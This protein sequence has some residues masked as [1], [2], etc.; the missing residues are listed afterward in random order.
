MMSSTI[1]AG[2]IGAHLSRR[3]KCEWGGGEGSVTLT[4]YWNGIVAFSRVWLRF[5]KEPTKYR[6]LHCFGWHDGHINECM[7][8]DIPWPREPISVATTVLQMIT[9]SK[10]KIVGTKVLNQAISD[11]ISTNYTCWQ[12]TSFHDGFVFLTDHSEKLKLQQLVTLF[13]G[14]HL[15]W[16]IATWILCAPQQY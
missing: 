6:S 1:G 8:F 5:H 3:Y 12:T 15:I 13:S 11:F 9:V 10:M 7:V 14:Y 4:L 2:Y 16:K